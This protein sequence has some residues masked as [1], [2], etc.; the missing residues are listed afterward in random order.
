MPRSPFSSV[1]LGDLIRIHPQTGFY[2]TADLGESKGRDRGR[3]GGEDEDEGEDGERDRV[4]GEGRDRDRVRDKG[5]DG[6]KGG[7]G[8]ETVT[9]VRMGR[10]TWMG[11]RDGDRH[12]DD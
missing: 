7:I 11:V 6:D 12:K 4:R 5:Q 1:F 10:G 2:P 8:T 3:E 9:G